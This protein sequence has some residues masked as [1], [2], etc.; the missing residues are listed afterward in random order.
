M[1]IDPENETSYA[2]Q[3]HEANLKYIEN[4][5]CAKHGHVPVNKLESFTE[6]HLHLLNN[7]FRI[8]SSIL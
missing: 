4:E 1:D 7:G 3:Y 6:Q 2:T 5:C 8:Q